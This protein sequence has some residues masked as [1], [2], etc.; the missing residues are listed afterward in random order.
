MLR[1]VHTFGK[2]AGDVQTLAKD[3]VRIGRAPDNDVVFDANYDRDA[4]SRRSICCGT[5]SRG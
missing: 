2:N 4:S 1:I 3:I 5:A